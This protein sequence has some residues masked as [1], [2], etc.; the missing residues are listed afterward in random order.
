MRVHHC[1]GIHE[2]P[3]LDTDSLRAGYLLE[4]L[5]LEGEIILVATDLDRAIVGSVVPLVSPLSLDAGPGMRADHFCERREL[6]I[7]NLGGTGSVTVDGISHEL[8]KLDCLYV[9]RGARDIV[10]ASA[11]ADQAAQF[12][13]LSYPAH[14]EYPVGKA[15]QAGANKL[16]LGSATEANVRHLYQCIH[17]QG[18]RSCQLVMG[19]T[20]L[21]P[22]SVWNTMPPH[23]HDRRSEVYLYFDLPPGQ[24]VAHFM[25]APDESRVLW[26]AEKQAVLSPPWSVHCGAGTAAYRFVWGMGGENQRFDDMDKIAAA[27]LR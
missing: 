17:E 11:A 1:P 14:A 9:G 12:Y 25:G 24:R 20:E 6:G 26:V 15:A 10:F 2:Y 19:C 18:I 7:L 22:G 8:A 23:T 3:L 4:D 13:L 27:D 21:Q 5:F 16:V